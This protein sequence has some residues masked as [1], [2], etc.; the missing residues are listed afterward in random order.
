M[1]GGRGRG[2]PHLEV[3]VDEP[4]QRGDGRVRDGVGGGVALDVPRREAQARV[5]VRVE[6]LVGGV[7]LGGR[8]AVGSGA[9]R[10]SRAEEGGG[11]RGGRRRAEEGGGGRMQ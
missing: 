4:A 1:C 3:L 9:R 2:R 6:G 11:G 7:R 10:T 8:A 5:G